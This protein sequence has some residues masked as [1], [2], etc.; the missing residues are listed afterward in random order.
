[1]HSATQRAVHT[2][3]VL[4]PAY[5]ESSPFGEAEWRPAFAADPSGEAR[6]LIPV[7]VQPCQPT[8]LLR[9]RVYIDV[10]DRGEPEARQA[11]LTGV[12]QRAGRPTRPPRFPGTQPAG[13]RGPRYPGA[14]PP[15]F[16]VPFASNPLLA[17]RAEDVTEPEATASAA[18]FGVSFDIVFLDP[19]YNLNVDPVLSAAAGYAQRVLVVERATRSADPVWPEGFEP[20]EPRR[21][22]D[23]TLWYGWRS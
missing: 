20:A 13:E 14:L 17:G 1:M 23:T 19:P 10:A 21:Y 12:E 11:L 15:V 22:G 3:P 9:T 6:T 7:R 2:I 5:L 16:G 4:S 8:G 18:R